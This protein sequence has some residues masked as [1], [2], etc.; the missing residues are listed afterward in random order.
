MMNLFNIGFDEHCERELQFYLS[1]FQEIEGWGV[2][3]LLIR[4]FRQLDSLQKE[5]G[6]S[7][8]VM[9]IG[10]HHGRTFILLDLL[11][12]KG[13][14]SL[15]IDLFET[16]QEFNLDQSGSGNRKFFQDNLE[17]YLPDVS[18]VR[19][20]QGNT[21]TLEKEEI[22][23]KVD[24][25]A[26]R[27]IHIDGGHFKEIVAND[28]SL[29]QSILADGGVIIVDDYWHSG[30]PGVQEGV[31]WFMNNSPVVKLVPI[32]TGN[33]KL[34]LTT[35]GFHQKFIDALAD[36]LP[37]RRGKVIKQFGYDSLCLDEH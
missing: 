22:L 2:D 3:E 6:V 21:L 36:L 20:I 24:G 18:C 16:M 12:R 30:F 26:V 17:K 23:K 14:L 4:V 25:Q 13:E 35:H 10:V 27:L 33:N 31:Q 5:W 7:G 34:F 19:I 9:E 1:H 37:G 11:R 29:S 8:S 28:L 32:L 15:A